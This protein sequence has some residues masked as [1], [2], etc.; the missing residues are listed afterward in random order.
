MLI[1]IAILINIIICVKN[2][3]MRVAKRE[4]SFDRYVF[5]IF[6]PIQG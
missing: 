6:R 2:K 5:F 3:F 1:N 4:I